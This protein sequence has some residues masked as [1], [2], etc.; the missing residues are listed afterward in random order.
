M[1][2]PPASGYIDPCLRVPVCLD[3]ISF[4][5]TANNLAAVDEATRSRFVVIHVPRPAPE[6]FL[7]ILNTVVQSERQRHGQ[8]PDLPEQAILRIFRA[9]YLAKRDIRVLVKAYREELSTLLL[10][11]YRLED[12]VQSVIH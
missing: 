4:I 10:L 12:P 11:M 5:A 1:M 6:H 7:T 3:G 2:Q 8:T 9:W